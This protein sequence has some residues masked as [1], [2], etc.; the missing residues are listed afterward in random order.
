MLVRVNSAASG[1]KEYLET[2]R[3]KGRE[4]DRELIDERLPLAGDIEL[5]DDVIQSIQTQQEGDS[6]Y[7]HITLGFAEQFTTAL[8]CGPGQVNAE[9]LREVVDAYRELL[10]AAYDPSEYLF[11]AEAHIPKVTHEL[12]ASTGD[13]ESR[14]PHVHIV[15][16]KRNLESDRYLDPLSYGDQAIGPAQAIQEHINQR[17]GLKSP[18]QSRR[19]PAAPQ[20]PLGRHAASFEGQSPKQI[21]AYLSDLVAQGHVDSFEQLIEAASFIGVTTI[22]DGK[23]GAYLNIKPD[24]ADRGINLRDLGREGFDATA[25]SLRAAVDAPD[26]DLLAAQWKEQGAFEVRYANGSPR[27]RAAYK[28]M[29]PEERADFLKRAKEATQARLAAYDVPIERQHTEAAAEAIQRAMARV[30]EEGVPTPR[31]A[32]LAERIKTLIKEIKNGRPERAFG[33]VGNTDRAK[34]ADGPRVR[35]DFGRDG[36]AVG[37]WSGQ[38]AGEVARPAG[39]QLAADQGASRN[40]TDAE[41]KASTDPQL[42]LDAARERFGIDPADYV[43]AK[44]KDGTPRLIHDGRQ[45][46]LG[47]FFTKHLQ[48]P[49]AEAREILVDCHARTIAN[50]TDTHEA[51]DPGEDRQ[52]DRSSQSLLSRAAAAI[53]RGQQIADDAD[54]VA[55][56]FQRRNLGAALEATL[57][58]LREDRPKNEAPLTPAERIERA[59]EAISR[60]TDRDIDPEAVKAVLGRRTLGQAMS[61]ALHSLTLDRPERR[62]SATVIEAIAASAKPPQQDPDRLKTDTSPAIVLTAAQK[63]YGIDPAD[64][65]IGTGSDGSPRIIHK[66]KQYN[67]GD[68]FTKHLQR[69]WAE[70]QT[71]LR[72]CYHASISDALPPPDKVLWR[73]F[74]QWRDRQFETVAA[75]RTSDGAAFRTRVLDTREEYKRRKAEAQPLP[76]RQRAAAVARARADQFIAQQVIAAD[77][78]KASAAA[79]IPRRNAH[80]REFLVELASAGDTAALGELRRMA[81]HQPEPEAKISGGRSQPVFPLPSYIVDAKGAVTYRAGES[82][83]VRDSSQ[84]VTVLRAETNAYDAAIRVAIAR[85]G[86]TLTLNGDTRFVSSMVEA[87]RRTG[88]EITLRDVTRPRAAPINVNLRDRE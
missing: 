75:R 73:Q 81:P 2:G 78:A 55:R 41:L 63:L 37:R 35:E 59:R 5:L 71:V 49:W 15:I 77:R 56:Y 53:A 52:G 30:E 19:D 76:G 83:I 8:E 40:L 82:A 65:V 46:N 29:S 70:A 20:H 4:Y 3:K 38:D 88:L 80:Y 54:K 13:Y 84:G 86:R 23:D 66:D 7:L 34:P 43:A 25:Q 28:A 58:G 85:Y 36:R 51:T 47:D 60:A 16:P 72:D 64:Y 50:N 1:I 21:R 87:A 39:R 6:R 62:K 68:F 9:R 31:P 67:L 33:S 24:W 44:G 32:G 17:F 48:R 12:N 57:R 18:L 74:S 27:M 26:F 22:R 61:L 42:V 79:R 69:P 11:Y 14:L 10:M 45:Y